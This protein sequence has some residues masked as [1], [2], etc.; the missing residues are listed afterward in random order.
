MNL[1]E[2]GIYTL[3]AVVEDKNGLLWFAGSGGVVSLNPKND[4]WTIYTPERTNFPAYEI[5]SMVMDE[6][7]ILFLG[8]RRGS[9]Q[10]R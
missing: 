9:A 10:F 6:S 7:G 2:Y 5:S 8:A 3:E 4:G 1:A